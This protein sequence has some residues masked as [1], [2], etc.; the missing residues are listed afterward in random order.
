MLVIEIVDSPDEAPN[1]NRDHVDVRAAT[2]TKA[3]I[4]RT[5]TKSG[6]STVDFQIEALDGSK[7]V[8]ML[9][10]ALVVQLAQAV[11]GAESR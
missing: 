10:G 4:V 2:I 8:A 9:T 11:I 5:G 1:Y 7:F 6:K 3:L